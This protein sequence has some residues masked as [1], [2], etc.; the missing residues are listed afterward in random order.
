MEK[1]QRAAPAVT[2]GPVIHNPQVIEQLKAQGV[3]PVDRIE[4][5]APGSRV[6]LRSHGVDRATVERLR[7]LG[8]ELV[9]A[10]CPFVS[11]IHAIAQ[12]ADAALIVVGE[13]AH[14]E[15]QGILGWADVD[16]Y[17]VL[18]EADVAALPPLSRAVVVAQTT[19]REDVYERVAALL[20]Q[21]I[22]EIAFHATICPATHERQS[23]CMELARSCDAMIVIGGR[24]SSN[25]RK[26]Y[27]LA[28]DCCSRTCF[29]ETAAELDGSFS[30]RPIP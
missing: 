25:S 3:V 1:A 12:R 18:T 21:R 22:P 20:K 6:V 29:I 2:L 15:V 7:A 4:D 5:I 30:G 14:P 19:L 9:D 26:L 28:K 13:A 16:G 10:T 24:Q 11:R 27:A 8:C 17:A 23:E